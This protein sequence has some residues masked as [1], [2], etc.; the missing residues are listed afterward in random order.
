MKIVLFMISM[1]L[2]AMS[3]YT[4]LL[5]ED[6]LS[7]LEKVTFSFTIGTGLLSFYLFGLL[8]LHISFSVWSIVPFF[9]PFLIIGLLAWKKGIKTTRPSVPQQPLL[10]DLSVGKKIIFSFLALLVIWKIIFGA[11]MIFSG[12]TTFWDAYTLWNYK[13]KVI[14]YSNGAGAEPAGENIM[15]G[16]YRHYPLHL[17]LMRAWIATFLGEWDDSYVNLHSLLLFLCLL[18]LTF[19]FLRKKAGTMTAMILTCV[20]SGMPILIYNAFSGYADM[21]VGYYYLGAI[22]MLFYWHMSGKNSFLIYAGIISSTAMFT[23]NEGIA[24]VF[25]A[26]FSTVLVHLPFSKRRWKKTILSI[27]LFL[28][29]SASILMWLWKSGALTAILSISGIKDSLVAFHPEGLMPLADFSLLYRSFNLFW[30]GAMLTVI[31]NWKK[32]FQ[33]E[34]RFFLIPAILSLFAVLFVFLFTPNVEWLINGT[35]INRTLLIVVPVLTISAG[36]LVAT[37]RA[38]SVRQ[39]D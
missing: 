20:L 16:E 24:I 14:Y 12:P 34:V 15:Q 18:A 36:L 9:V 26:L 30:A 27:A 31:L 33:P 1:L 7:R 22:I 21:A 28:V 3:G 8:L 17:P 35:T 23:K 6:H 38:P 37:G 19:E 32:A 13:S 39:T 25:P 5:R 4:L 29:S 2:P 10:T 11:Y